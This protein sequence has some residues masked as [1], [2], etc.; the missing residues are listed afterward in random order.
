MESQAVA[1][2]RLYV[3]LEISILYIGKGLSRRR[4]DGRH[5]RIT[6][7]QAVAAAEGHVRLAGDDEDRAGELVRHGSAADA[8]E[9]AERDGLFGRFA[10]IQQVRVKIAGLKEEQLIG[11]D[12]GVRE[13][14]GWI[15]QGC[16]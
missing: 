3:S 14:A 8:E 11:G 5:F 15:V 1:C 13:V 6:G 16:S 7:G 4:G 9:L 10:Q 12:V 2:V